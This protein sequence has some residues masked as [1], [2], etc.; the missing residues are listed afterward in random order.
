[1][2]LFVFW[3]QFICICHAFCIG[4]LDEVLKFYINE[5]LSSP[6]VLKE[7]LFKGILD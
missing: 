7:L 1:M 4:P 5:I 3:I 6:C 2:M